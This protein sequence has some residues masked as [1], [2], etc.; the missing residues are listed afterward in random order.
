MSEGRRSLLNFDIFLLLGT[1]VLLTVGI[2][3]VYSSSIDSAGVRTNN[4][5][6]RQIVWATTGIALL[7]VVAFLDYRIIERLAPWLYLAGLVLLL[8][9][10]A[11]GIVVNGARSWLGVSELSIQPSEFAK[12]STIVFAARYLD[13]RREA[14]T[15]TRI[16]VSGL[17]IALPAG[18]T[19][20]QPDL[21]TASVFLPVYIILLIAS[22][23]PWGIIA[24]LLATLILTAIF[25]VLPAWATYLATRPSWAASAVSDPRLL[26]VLIAT[27]IFVGLLALIGL[28]LT[29]RRAFSWVAVGGGVFAGSL[30]LAWATRQAL[31][32]FQI[33]RLIVFLDPYV[34]PQ[35]SGWNIIQS[36]TA[37]GSGGVTGKGFLQGTQS[38]YRYLP[39]QST[40]F[41]FSIISEEWGFIGAG[42]LLL[43]LLLILFRGL[44][45]A[46]ES[47]DR[48]GSY[49][50]VGIV[51]YIGYHVVVNV[52][53]TIGVMPI[54]GIPLPLLSHGG[55]SLWTTL[56]SIGLLMSIFY[57]RYRT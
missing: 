45:I 34:D 35:G 24:T 25:A 10:L 40:D 27:A 48:F 26:P 54:T 14:S 22:D 37:V 38:H 2:L 17:I 36:M 30:S 6:L 33:M 9:T 41:I 56:L 52:G 16:A 31:R 21:G 5:Y 46:R 1:A 3:F 23:I 42:T 51:A 13:R 43:I 53:M 12:L 11:F 4:E 32:P 15:L 50:A 7:L 20:M 19:L 18:L 49:V 8:L 29:E 57:H 39:K 47:R 44:K 28:R 55:S